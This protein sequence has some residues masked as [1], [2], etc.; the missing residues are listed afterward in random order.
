MYHG[1][2][3]ISIENGTNSYAV[4]VRDNHVHVLN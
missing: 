2:K 3:D 1:A 4:Q